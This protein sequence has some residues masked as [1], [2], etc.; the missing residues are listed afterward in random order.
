[1]RVIIASDFNQTI[2][3]LDESVVAVNSLFLSLLAFSKGLFEAVLLEKTRHQLV[4]RSDI[5][6]LS[7]RKTL[8]RC[9]FRSSSS[10]TIVRF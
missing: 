8:S 4:P 5:S 2:C 9:L 6:E 10:I 3:V 1:A 7:D